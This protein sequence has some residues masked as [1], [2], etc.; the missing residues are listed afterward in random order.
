MFYV[1]IKEI[2]L[3]IGRRTSYEGGMPSSQLGTRPWWLFL[4]QL[5]AGIHFMWSALWHDNELSGLNSKQLYVTCYEM[6]TSGWSLLGACPLGL[7]QCCVPC[8]KIFSR[9]IAFKKLFS[10]SEF[11]VSRLD[12]TIQCPPFSISLP[13]VPL[14]ASMQWMNVLGTTGRG[15]RLGPTVMYGLW[16][17]LVVNWDLLLWNGGCCEL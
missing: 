13:L 6:I 15:C 7:V 10:P 9:L 2:G 17:G 5:K 8:R 4:L 3:C 14:E 12:N 11:Y 1:G 16:N